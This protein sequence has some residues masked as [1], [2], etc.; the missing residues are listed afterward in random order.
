MGKKIYMRR[1]DKIIDI[2]VIGGGASGLVA[3]LAAAKLG[4][5]REIPL[6]VTVLERQDRVAKKLLA[7]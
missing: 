5:E 2:A 3:A 1:E 6:T 7:T 4:A